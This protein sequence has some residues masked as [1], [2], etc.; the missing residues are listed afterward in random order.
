MQLSANATS[1]VPGAVDQNYALSL[2]S[3]QPAD[4]QPANYYFKASGVDLLG[5]E[6]LIPGINSYNNKWIAL[7]GDYAKSVS[8][9]S[10]A[11]LAGLFIAGPVTAGISKNDSASS[12]PTREDYAEILSLFSKS[13]QAY[14]FTKP[15]DKSVFINQGYVGKETVDGTK[16]YHYTLGVNKDNYVAYCKAVGEQIIQSD[17]YRRLARSDDDSIAADLEANNA[18]CDER[19]G[20]ISQNQKIDMWVDSQYKVLYKLRFH[21]SGKDNSYYEVGQKY[22]GKDNLQIFT[23][24]V[25]GGANSNLAATVYVNLK[26]YTAQ[27]KID[28]NSKAGQNDTS[29]SLIAETK[30][31]NEDVAVDIP[32]GAVPLQTAVKE[33]KI[34]IDS[35]LT[36]SGGLVPSNAD[37]Y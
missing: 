12:A 16:T 14:L 27:I 24:N 20:S 22:R 4:N 8:Q 15:G 2:V 35:I 32:A 10:G 7:E 23:N 9:N 37:S 11:A 21:E 26:T 30:P 3:K 17:S 13:S 18:V 28:Y 33:L 19:A 25:D 1:K 5:L 34:D 36:P 31:T 6:G 29:F